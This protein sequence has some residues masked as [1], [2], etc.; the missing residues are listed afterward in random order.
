MRRRFLLTI[1]SVAAIV[2]L[3]DAGYYRKWF[4]ARPVQYWSD[5]LSEKIDNPDRTAI[6]R[7][8]F[9][10]VYTACMRAR[11]VATKKNIAHPVILL[12]PNSFYRDSLHV[13]PD[14]YAP[15]PSVFY[16]YTSLEGVWT[17]SPNVGKANFLL[18]VT[19]TSVVLEQITGAAQ[20]QRILYAY[21]KYPPTP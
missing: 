4:V 11:E 16:Y 20:L 18:R 1:V 3:L 9:G 2:I 15:E 5:F 7:R 14:I 8:R 19:K 21:K 10:M 17:N 6:N 12:E 13:Y